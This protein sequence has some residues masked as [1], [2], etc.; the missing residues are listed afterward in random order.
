MW[1]QLGSRCFPSSRLGGLEQWTNELEELTNQLCAEGMRGGEDLM[2]AA[3]A[4]EIARRYRAML[5]KFEKMADSTITN[6]SNAERLNRILQELISGG[7]L[8]PSEMASRRTSLARVL[9]CLH[10]IEAMTPNVLEKG[11]RWTR[12]WQND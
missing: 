2:D 12:V 9:N 6:I 10:D 11:K 5:E 8:S 7:G 1:P 4:A 3:V